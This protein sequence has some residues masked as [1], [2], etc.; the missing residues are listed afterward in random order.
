MICRWISGRSQKRLPCIGRSQ[1]SHA[2]KLHR[3]CSSWLGAL[4]PFVSFQ[5][6]RIYLPAAASSTDCR[7]D[8]RWFRF[9][10][11]FFRSTWKLPRGISSRQDVRQ[12][13]D[14]RDADQFRWAKEAFE[15]NARLW[16]RWSA[17]IAVGG[18]DEKRWDGFAF[19]KDTRLVPWRMWFWRGE[20]LRS[21]F[22]LPESTDNLQ[23]QRDP[24]L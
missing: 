12:V 4:V 9:S 22:L 6:T 2:S 17:G 7:F 19:D 13:C 3:A 16:S 23:I 14:G 20:R 11:R 5:R 24:V 15:L 8:S 10:S 1:S 18:R 21:L